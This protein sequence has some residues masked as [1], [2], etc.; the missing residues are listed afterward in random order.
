LLGTD[1]YS[2][3]QEQWVQEVGKEE[4]KGRCKVSGWYLFM[5]LHVGE[6]Y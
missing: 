1:W 4:G 3:V 2:L 6:K 5:E